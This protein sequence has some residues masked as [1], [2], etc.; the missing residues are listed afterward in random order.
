MTGFGDFANIDIEQLM[1]RGDQQIEEMRRFESVMSGLVGRAQDED[2][3]VTV[4]YAG[5][6]L[7]ELELHP[8]A[9]RLSSGELAE[10]IK[11]TI[12]AAAE[13][14]QRQVEEA[15]EEVFGKENDPMKL[16]KEPD[17]AMDKVREAEG[18]YGRTFDDVMAELDRIR[19]RL[20]SD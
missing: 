2:R 9:M 5:A 1:R 20:G 10:K 4:E 14:M 17:A 18:I 15:S 19:R 7:R 11:E 13:D 3:L 16:L 8:K 12:R 6:G